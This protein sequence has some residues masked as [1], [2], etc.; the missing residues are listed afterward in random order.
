M[1]RSLL[2]SLLLCASAF[3]QSTPAKSTGAPT[4]VLMQKVIAAWNTGDPANAAAFYDKTPTNVYFD[5]APLQYHGWKE[6]AEGVKQMFATFESMKFTLH[7]DAKVHRAGNTAWGTATWS[8]DGKLKTG[9]GVSLEGRW[10]VIWE[11]KGSQWLVV[12]EH[13]SAP[14]QPEPE[15]RHR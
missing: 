5:I 15:S 14:W 6:Y 12:H 10:T 4:A 2:I 3:A 13:F 11:K 1:Y 9:N 7:N 8:A